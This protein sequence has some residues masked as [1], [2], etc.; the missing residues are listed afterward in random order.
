MQY[1][2]NE[3]TKLQTALEA[4]K[5]QWEEHKETCGNDSKVD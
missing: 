1:A 5:K 3:I 2:T 4:L